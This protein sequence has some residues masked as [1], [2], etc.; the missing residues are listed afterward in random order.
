[1]EKKK[2]PFPDE[3]P[4][5]LSP[6]RTEHYTNWEGRV[7]IGPVAI[8]ARLEHHLNNTVLYEMPIN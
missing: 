7:S 1:L 2:I 3:F 8:K 4:K 6:I 5:L